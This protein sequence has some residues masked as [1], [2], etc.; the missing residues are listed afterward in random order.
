MTKLAAL[1]EQ[2]RPQPIRQGSQPAGKKRVTNVREHPQK[3]SGSPA[4]YLQPCCISAVL[5]QICSPAA[6]LQSCCISAVTPY[7]RIPHWERTLAGYI[8][9]ARNLPSAPS[10]PSAPSRAKR[11]VWSQRERK[12][13]SPDRTPKESADSR[14]RWTSGG[15]GSQSYVLSKEPN[16]KRLPSEGLVGTSSRAVFSSTGAVFSSTGIVLGP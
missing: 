1:G 9:S 16:K 6:Y 4:A 10:G 7:G 12:Y 15:Q 13:R 5:L 2:A 11:A 8:V 3:T 14:R